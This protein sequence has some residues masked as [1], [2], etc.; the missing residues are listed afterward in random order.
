MPVRCNSYTIVRAGG[1]RIGNSTLCRRQ[2]GRYI[3]SV[4]KRS[5]TS[6]CVPASIASGSP[7]IRDTPLTLSVYP[8]RGHD[9]AM[10][11]FL[12]NFPRHQFFIWN[13]PAAL[14][15]AGT[16]IFITFASYIT[17]I[18]HRHRPNITLVAEQLYSRKAVDGSIDMFPIHS[19][20]TKQTIDRADDSSRKAVNEASYF[21]RT[22][23]QRDEIHFPPG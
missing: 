20:R 4:F 12:W 19:T 9:P 10:H 1:S 17:V 2:W 11:L 13:R 6:S 7:F 23:D 8:Y 14:C 15:T 5:V 21:L 18:F 16:N 3:L 22:A